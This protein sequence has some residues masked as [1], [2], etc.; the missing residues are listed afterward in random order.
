MSDGAVLALV[1]SWCFIRY[2]RLCGRTFKRSRALPN[3]AAPVSDVDKFLWRKIFDHNPLFTM[4][5][6]KLASKTYAKSVCPELKFAEIFWSGDDP[7]LIPQQVLAGSVVVK[8]N[9]GSRWNVMVQNGRVDRA[10]MRKRAS[11]WMKRQ[12]GRSF[13][14]WGYK[15]ATRCLFVEEMLLEDG[16]PTQSEYKFHIS[17]GQTAFVFLERK[18][19]QAGEQKFNLD[20]DGQLFAPSVDGDANLLNFSRPACFQRMRSI[21]ERLAEPFDYVRCDLYELDGEIYFSELTVYPTSGVGTRNQKLKLKQL[22]NTMWDLR[23]SWFLTT[24]QTGWR[25][26]YAATMRK[27]LDENALSSR[28]AAS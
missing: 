2:P 13:G 23:R 21:A 11:G 15:H 16:K 8:A 25:K 26:V 6:D 19:E 12:Y 4:A 9:H 20:R 24:P 3:P 14:E 7:K 1:R 27:W 22:R 5:C 18:T 17:G 28:A 10:A